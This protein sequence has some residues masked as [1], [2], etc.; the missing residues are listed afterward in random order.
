MNDFKLIT[1]RCFTSLP[2]QLG[3]DV[4]SY[5][6]SISD[7]QCNWPSVVFSTAQ[8]SLKFPFI[9]SILVSTESKILKRV[10]TGSTQVN[11]FFF[12]L[13]KHLQTIE[14]QNSL[15]PKVALVRWNYCVRKVWKTE[16]RTLLYYKITQ[17][18]HDLIF[19]PFFHSFFRR[20]M[21]Y[22]CTWKENMEFQWQG[23]LFSS[24]WWL[25]G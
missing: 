25:H 8:W 12:M 24:C 10:Y 13:L 1:A 17:W 19:F 22:R 2:N 6:K 11:F 14:S 20:K 9:F 3:H 7:Q 23:N 16:I 5:V 21:D 15:Q 4:Q 18:A